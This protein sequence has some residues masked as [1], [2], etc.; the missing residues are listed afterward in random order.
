MING[1]CAGNSNSNSNNDSDSVNTVHEP[2][3]A[4]PDTAM[5]SA[6]DVDYSVETLDSATPGDITLTVE[7]AYDTVAGVFT[8]RGNTRRDMAMAGHIKGTPSRIEKD[9]EFQTYFDTTHT[10]L[11]T[12][13]GGSGWTGQP[14]LVEWTPEQ[15]ASIKSTSPALTADFKSQEIIV[16]SLCGKVYFLDFATG[17]ISRQPIDVGNPIKGTVSLDPALNGSLYVGQG[18]PAHRPFGH[19]A[20]DLATH[21]VDYFWPEDHKAKRNWGAY[22]SS[23]VVVGDFL[24]WP[25]E[26]GSVYKYTRQGNGKLKMHSAL[27]YTIKGDGTGAGIES[28]MCVY[29]NYGYVGDNH[30]D[31]LCI[32]LNT[33]KPVWHYDNGD[34]I[35]ASLVLEVED[36]VPYIYAGCEVD[37]QGVTGNCN[38]VKLNGLTGEPAWKRSIECLRLDMGGKHFDGGLYSTP[39]LG[40]GDCEGLMFLNMC[41]PGKSHASE[42][43]A[44]E[45]KTGNTVY[46]IP[47]KAWA[48]SSP[49]PFY[50]END[51]LYIMAGDSQGNA[52]LIDAKAGKILFTEH[53][54]NNFESSPVVK[55]NYAVVGSRGDRIYRFAIK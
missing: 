22:D 3:V 2:I 45:R 29:R 17:R 39:L 31:I 47:L 44:I 53:M 21:K 32:N 28:S 41:Q 15:M 9:W 14:L 52:Y 46:A 55:D 35:D 40:H 49:V 8:F 25:A 1:G 50:N 10:S 12:W 33:M 13:G 36:G 19:M 23:P 24:F 20:V 4:L 54:V 43:M 42:F 37:R 38:L 26:N 18:V 5:P 11:G 16:G 51:K 48:W 34:D 7:S 30:G 27:R 6:A